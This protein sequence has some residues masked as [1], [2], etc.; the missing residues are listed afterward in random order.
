MSIHA[1]HRQRVKE[2]FLN[3]GLDDFR[4]HEV[5]EFLLFYCIP[6]K[7]TNEIAHR[8]IQ[9]FG[10]LKNVMKASVKDLAQI[11]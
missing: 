6:R 2:R 9:H 3:N 8:L 10:S 11:E 5:L 1:G 4:E 7:N